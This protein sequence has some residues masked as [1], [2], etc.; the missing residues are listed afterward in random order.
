MTVNAHTDPESGLR[1]YTW[2]GRELPSVTSIRR[3]IGMPFTLH[4]WTLSQVIDRAIT[5]HA[6]ID[7]MLVRPKRPRERT[8]EA[9]V[10]K[11]VQQHLRRAATEERDR[12]GDKGTR[13]HAAIADGLDLS[14]CDPD[15][16][17]FVAQHHDFM[18]ASGA[19][20]LWAERQVFNLKYGYA[21]TGDVLLL[22]PAGWPKAQSP[23]RIVVTDLKTSKGVYLDH[24]V[25]VMAYAMGEF[26]GENDVV[27]A[28]ATAQLHAAS[29]LGILHLSDT[30]WEW[31]EIRPEP[32]LF[33]GFVGSLAFATFLHTNDNQIDALIESRTRGG[34]L[35]PALA[36]SLHLIEGKAH[37][38]GD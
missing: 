8:R 34:T 17:G 4:N 16:A 13:A 10:L 19:K 28:G 5:D 12:A 37:N 26:V 21:G 23:E 22:I 7:S 14:A 15:V 18:R 38:H 24:A 3:L 32:T 2:K 20:T 36:R 9:N 1:F 27:D 35:V 25:Q 29:A 33:Q 6:V 31:I 30:T 11:E